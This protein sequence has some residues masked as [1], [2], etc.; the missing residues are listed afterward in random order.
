MLHD[1]GLEITAEKSAKSARTQETML[2]HT[3]QCFS[4]RLLNHTRSEICFQTLEHQLVVQLAQLPLPVAQPPLP[5]KRKSR[6]KRKSILE[7]V[8]SS[9]RRMMDIEH[10]LPMDEYIYVQ[11][12][13]SVMVS[14]YNNREGEEI[15]TA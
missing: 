9:M 2:S 15:L 8:V 14:I 5:S 12:P 7:P 6:K 11:E 3:G 4:P 10:A 1:D 13:L